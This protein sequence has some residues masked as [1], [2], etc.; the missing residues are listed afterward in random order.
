MEEEQNPR[1]EPQVLTEA[2]WFQKGVLQK[3]EI[4]PLY[5]I[6]EKR[7]N[8]KRYSY[9]LGAQCRN[10]VDNKPQVVFANAAHKAELTIQTL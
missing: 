2:E 5:V 6:K 7:S 8:F 1:S 4:D 3:A 10:R 9:L